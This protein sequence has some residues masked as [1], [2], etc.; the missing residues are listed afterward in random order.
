MSVWSVLEENVA[1]ESIC[2]LVCEDLFV[3]CPSERL[4]DLVPEVGHA[5]HTGIFRVVGVDDAHEVIF[6]ESLEVEEQVLH[7]LVVD[8]F[9]CGEP[10]E[11]AG[12]AVNHD[13]AKV[14]LDLPPL[15]LGKDHGEK[16]EELLQVED[17]DDSEA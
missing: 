16:H 5:G 3:N 9:V 1:R 4:A 14:H 2:H 10:G 6:G 12:Q 13:H 11:Q 7:H 8:L 17:F 15:E